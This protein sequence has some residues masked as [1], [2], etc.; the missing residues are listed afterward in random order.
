MKSWGTVTISGFDSQPEQSFEGYRRSFDCDAPQK[1]D[2]HTQFDV[3]SLTKI[4]F[5]TN[6]VMMSVDR[7]LLKVDDLV[8]KY[9]PAWATTDKGVITIRDLL[10]H[11]SGLQPWLPLYVRSQS[12]KDAFE[13]I[14]QSQLACKPREKRIYSDLGFIA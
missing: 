1:M 8:Q 11:Q 2:F 6:M 10:E 14:A 13:V 12:S 9:L 7:G 5:T 3:A 4:I